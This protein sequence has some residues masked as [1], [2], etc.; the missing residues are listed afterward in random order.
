MIWMMNGKYKCNIYKYNI[1]IY[2]D[3]KHV[4]LGTTKEFFSCHLD[5][6]DS[7]KYISRYI[8]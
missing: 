2:I 8:V 1:Y 5:Q 6:I 4:I 3:Y 7:S